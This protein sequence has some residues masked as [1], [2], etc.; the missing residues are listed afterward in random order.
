MSCNVTD[1][2]VNDFLLKYGYVKWR[3]PKGKQG[4]YRIPISKT[5]A[6]MTAIEELTLAA[7]KYGVKHPGP[8]FFIRQ[9]PYNLT[10][11]K[12]QR[13]D[14]LI[15]KG[16]TYYQVLEEN[17]EFTSEFQQKYEKIGKKDQQYELDFDAQLRS[18]VEDNFNDNPEFFDIG[19][20]EDFANFL[21]EKGKE[22]D[23]EYMKSDEAFYDFS[24]YVE[25]K[26]RIKELEKD[27]ERYFSPK[28]YTNTRNKT[29]LSEEQKKNAT[30]LTL[31]VD[32]K[33][34]LLQKLRANLDRF[35]K[36]NKGKEYTENFTR[37][38]AQ[39]H[40]AINR[41]SEEIGQLT[42]TDAN[43][44]FKDIVDEIELLSN[45]LDNLD[46][47]NTE[48]HEIVNRLNMLSNIIL[49]QNIDDTSI[50]DNRIM[51]DG[52]GIEGFDAIRS[53]MV[54]LK[55]KFNDFLYQIAKDAFLNDPIFV[56]NRNNPLRKES[57]I[58]DEQVES[59]LKSIKEKG[60]DIG[61]LPAYFLGINSNEDSIISKVLNDLFQVN[62]KKVRQSI[63]EKEDRLA[64]LQERLHRNK[65]D[66]D[67]FYGKDA[68]GVKTGRLISKFTNKWLNS[69]SAMLDIRK[70]FESANN[71][72][73][74]GKYKELMSWHQKNSVFIDIRKIGIFKEL[75]ED[76]FGEYFTFSEEEMQN[77][78]DSLRD[79]LGR[80]Y[81]DIIEDQVESVE[82]F[83][84]YLYAE[85]DRNNKWTEKNIAAANPFAF[86]ENYYSE[87]RMNPI[88]TTVEDTPVKVFNTGRFNNFIPLRNN[89]D[90]M[91]N[92]SDTGYYDSTFERDF[93]NND[94]AY[95]AQ[96]IMQSLLSEHI[97]P[98]YSVAGKN[99]SALQIPIERKSFAEIY[100]DSRKKG[101]L[102]MIKA[103]VHNTIEKWKDKWFDA[104][105]NT[106]KRDIVSNYSNA[107]LREIRDLKSVLSLLPNSELFNRAEKLG[108]NV[109]KD[110]S[111]ELLIDTIARA[112][113]L[114][115]FSNDIFKNVLSV[116]SMASLQRARQDTAFIAEMLYK[117]YIKGDGQERHKANMKFR[118]WIDVQIYNKR[119]EKKADENN[120]IT[121]LSIKR[122]S[123]A[124]KEMRDILKEVQT[125]AK[126]GNIK[127]GLRF[128]LDG[129]KFTSKFNTETLK[130]EYMI[131][132]TEVSDDGESVE[133][134]TKVSEKTFQENLNTYIEN[135]IKN[136]GIK[137]T[138]SSFISGILSN[139]SMGF[140]GFNIKA[141]IRNRIE[142]AIVNTA[143]DA[144]G[145]RWTTGNNRKSQKILAGAS[146]FK[147]SNGKLDFVSRKKAEQLRTIDLLVKRFDVLQDRK[148]FR[149][150]KNQVSAYD[151][152][153]DFWDVYNFAVGL[154]EYSNQV[155]I[156]LN[157]LQD[158][159][160]KDY[161]GRPIGFCNGDGIITDE[162]GKI[163]DTHNYI[164]I[165]YPGTLKL[166]PEYK[167]TAEAFNE[168]GTLKND[169][170]LNDYINKDNISLETF[171]V[172]DVVGGV[173]EG[174]NAITALNLRI[175][176]SIKIQGN[177]SNMDSIYAMHNDWG[178]FAMAF[179]RF[180]P[181]LVNQRFG[182]SGKDII[183]GRD[184]T[185]GRYRVLFRN[186]GALGV[187]ASGA[188][189]IGFG[190]LIS[191]LALTSGLIPFAFQRVA[192]KWFN[193]D[194]T[195]DFADNLLSAAGMLQEVLIRTINMPL[196]IVN[197]KWQ[198][199][200]IKGLKENVFLKKL[201][202]KQVLTEEETGAIKATAQELA[203]G[204]SVILFTMLAKSAFGG[205]DDDEDKK[206]T[207]NFI[208]NF[209]NQIIDNLMMFT[210]PTALITDG[211]RL[212]LLAE[213]DNIAKFC[214][215]VIKYNEGSGSVE[216]IIH[217]A[218]KAQ[219]LVP[220]F[221]QI[222]KPIE[223]GDISFLWQDDYEFKKG[224]WF[225]KAMMSKE[226]KI[227]A[228]IKNDR[229]KLRAKYTKELTERYE[230]ELGYNREEAEKAAEK[231]ANKMLSSK[232]TT[233]KPGETFEELDERTDFGFLKK[234][235]EETVADVE[236]TIED[237][238]ED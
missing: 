202:N 90:S 30:G 117:Q 12:N 53:S 145:I 159:K 122:L 105:Y 88:S 69:V 27:Y 131:S 188:A 34:D 190:P 119:N 187:F 143:V 16:I 45:S 50:E 83:V 106:D 104:N 39:F 227:K 156:M 35:Y 63:L 219:P 20:K 192:N 80:A 218:V 95:E 231:L 111:S 78:E 147:T 165:Y 171:E 85:Q 151:K 154:P 130:M 222:Y 211:S 11:G 164:P 128:N 238:E 158:F 98:A 4:E 102:P 116:S 142:G 7:R 189:L 200:D 201:N 9:V 191:G 233:R 115:K 94:D 214:K 19:T 196:A 1:L 169:I 81:D 166:R 127:D 60:K 183:Q 18:K 216:D 33:R 124:D 213:L 210:N 137:M 17:M 225:D 56:E 170:D 229:A 58:T 167:Y 10:P 195:I 126:S 5:Q 123:D 138:L 209:G 230:E 99:I 181:E 208:D 146:L 178:R 46:T 150:K 3:E 66:I 49:G 133:N 221:T 55:N 139:M 186:P 38:V 86:L 103:V 70:N 136:T 41:V 100:A 23:T 93:E 174:S 198:L 204:I 76:E 134:I 21:L 57:E 237:L 129:K 2:A 157:I 6:T 152:F 62:V 48:N 162:N 26:N 42:A 96:K 182:V 108:L 71:L 47:F 109:P 113:V 37:R 25:E 149:D 84:N 43:T 215:A 51:L 67:K 91:G 112:E 224:Q 161:K 118:N 184:R 197:S 172:S 32:Y 176:D 234:N 207:R 177:F 179:K 141:G 8:M 15:Q 68:Y 24:D 74:P 73:K 82:K 160:V 79:T 101:I 36:L 89:I 226:D 223:K 205:D 61:T 28:E 64:E 29:T 199:E 120:V 173:A 72:L 144:E 114:P 193:K 14:N 40:E 77:Y 168:D 180:L 132:S 232:E 44:V 135:R 75:Y 107:A 217:K 65:F 148:D 203:I 121:K 87:N 236:L 155:E 185:E 194:I 212:L 97:N 125:D 13:I 140:L 59:W 206:Y 163:I 54:D 220:V 153:K 22:N 92:L 52:T 110:I 228:D 175:G 31:Y 235:V